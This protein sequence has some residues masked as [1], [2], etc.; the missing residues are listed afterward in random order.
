[1]EQPPEEEGIPQE[2]TPT[3]KKETL[4]AEVKRKTEDGIRSVFDALERFAEF[5]STKSGLEAADKI[6]KGLLRQQVKLEVS[7]MRLYLS[8]NSGV[9][10]SFFDRTRE[11]LVERIRN[12]P[13]YSHYRELGS[14]RAAGAQRWLLATY[15]RELLNTSRGPNERQHALSSGVAWSLLAS[16]GRRILRDSQQTIDGKWL[17]ETMGPLIRANSNPEAIKQ[18]LSRFSQGDPEVVRAV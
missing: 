3:E 10:D 4:L 17:S 6:I 12:L 16:D 9:A 2:Q 7:S 15:I 13:N 18:E 8:G 14:E 1:M 5:D 11:A